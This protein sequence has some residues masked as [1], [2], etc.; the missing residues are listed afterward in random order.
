MFLNLVGEKRIEVELRYGCEQAWNGAAR[1]NV[2]MQRLNLGHT[3][4]MR[5]DEARCMHASAGYRTFG[6][7]V[8]LTFACG[9]LLENSP[10]TLSSVNN[11]KEATW[12]I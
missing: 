1:Q 7:E 3:A 11:V 2:C 6:S 10:V 4:H 8:S 12:G 5:K 9:C